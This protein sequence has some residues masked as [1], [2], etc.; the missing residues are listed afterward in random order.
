MKSQSKEMQMSCIE[1]KKRNAAIV[2]IC[3][4]TKAALGGRKQSLWAENKR[5][6]SGK[7]LQNIY[8][9]VS[10]SWWMEKKSL[11]KSTSEYIKLLHVAREKAENRR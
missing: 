10:G 6:H 8:I 7:L 3:I 11:E 5:L 4:C 2:N 9:K 1:T